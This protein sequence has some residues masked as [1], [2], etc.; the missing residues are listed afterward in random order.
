ML[1]Q[2][3]RLHADSK[4]FFEIL[5]HFDSGLRRFANVL[6]EFFCHRQKIFFSFTA[7]FLIFCATS[8]VFHKPVLQSSSLVIHPDWGAYGLLEF[9]RPVFST[10]CAAL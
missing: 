8:P 9:F 3:V 4:S 5:F 1:L 6:F 10:A 2:F 7:V